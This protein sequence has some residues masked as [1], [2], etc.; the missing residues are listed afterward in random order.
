MAHPVATTEVLE[1]QGHVYE[2]RSVVVH[3]GDSVES[4]HYITL[5][6]HETD[7]GSW[8]LYNDSERKEASPEQVATTVGYRSWTVMKSYILFYEKRPTTQ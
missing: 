1:F 4:G 7:T 3:L 5:A 8:W 2:L 6:K